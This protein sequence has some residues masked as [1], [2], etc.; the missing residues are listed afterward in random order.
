LVPIFIFGRGKPLSHNY[1]LSKLEDGKLRDN[2][3]EILDE[4]I[5][6]VRGLL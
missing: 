3:P 5:E 6:T 4:L 1:V 2:S